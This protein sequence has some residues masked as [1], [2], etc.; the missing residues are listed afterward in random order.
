MPNK[1]EK[2]YPG[3]GKSEAVVSRYIGVLE[4]FANLA[5]KYLCWSL[6]FN[7]V[8]GLQLY[9]RDSNTGVFL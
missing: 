3:F 8:A 4:D 7:K 2:G 1:K 9:T 5:E 6:F